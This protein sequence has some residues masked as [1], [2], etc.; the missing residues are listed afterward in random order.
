MSLSADLF[1]KF[2]QEVYGADPFPWQE[3]AARRACAG[4]WPSPIGLPTAAGKTAMIDIAVFALACEAAHSARRI[5][6]VVDRRVV[7]DEA[8]ERAEK[9]ASILQ[10]KLFTEPSSI[11]GRVAA[12]LQRLAG[13]GDAAPLLVATLRGGIARDDSWTESP[14]QPTVCCSTVDQVGSSILFRAYGVRSAYNWPMRAALAGN[15]ALIIIDEAHTSRP[16]VQTMDLVRRYRAWAQEPVPATLTVVQ[17]SA[18]SEEEVVFPATLDAELANPI[19]RARWQAEKPTRL[20][21][22]EPA[23]GEHAE[24]GGFTALARALVEQARTVQGTGAKVVGVVANRVGTARRVFE[25]LS[26]ELGAKVVLFTGRARPY[27]R[28]RLWEECRGVVGI[29]RAEVPEA[30][31][32][33]VATQCIE[34]GANIDFDALV[35]ELA[36]IDA[37]EQRFGRLNRAG[38]PGPSL[39]VIVAQKDQINSK[40][41]DYIYGSAMPATWA[42][43]VN[44]AAGGRRGKGKKQREPVVDM[45]V[46]AI[47]SRSLKG[48][49]R[50]TLAPLRRDAPVLMPMHMDRLVQT[51]PVSALNPDVSLFLHG[52]QTGPADV[53]VVWRADIVERRPEDWADIVALCPP[54][55]SEA[56]MVPIWSV[57]RW[58]NNEQPPELADVEGMEGIE[59]VADGGDLVVRWRGADESG[60][61]PV[62]AIQP[63]DTIVVPSN[64]GGCD[65]WG[66]TGLRSGMVR[67]IGD[68]VRVGSRAI[69]RLH[70]KLVD[71]WPADAGGSE[72]L[73]AIAFGLR[74]ANR[75]EDARQELNRLSVH[76]AATVWVREAAGALARARRLRML[77]NPVSEGEVGALS[78]RTDFYQESGASAHTR[79]VPLES[80]LRESG[81]RAMQYAQALK[82]GPRLQATVM[83]AARLHDI[84]K[85]DPRFQAWLHGGVPVAQEEYLAKS[86]TNWQ[87]RAAIR[88]AREIAGYPAGGRHEL[89]S[90]AL[91]IAGKFSPPDEVDGELLLHL[92]ASHHGRCRP[93]APVV[94]DMN[95]VEVHYKALSAL[96]RHGLEST[97]SGLAERFW[98]LTRRY[99]WHGLAYLEMLVRLTD[100][101][102]S[103][104]EQSREAGDVY[105]AAASN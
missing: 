85:A 24:T 82:L 79:E 83:W 104:A 48:P 31:L 46:L 54:V 56:V 75:V 102:Q 5:F 71:E 21:P 73:R 67:D 89:Q 64:Y 44:S 9:L 28:D 25:E 18:T 66:W 2:F 55:A 45:G 34:V 80:H 63:G 17:M 37:L 47:R 81:D 52:P 1:A 62:S 20:V 74:T 10:R 39:G 7:V 6:F 91:L 35:T 50:L 43:L 22:V 27:D 98:K 93:F 105:A 14:L 77:P 103:E 26:K 49:D 41:V 36:S 4:A 3:E 65:D 69:L 42:F 32:F 15:D 58:M 76:R 88:R 57:R 70:D 101:R 96:S 53:Q 38:R 94:F 99:G 13:G 11:S 59:G 51:S 16:F 40:H 23:S 30:P 90:V 33:V 97:G 95:P 12:A 8:T 19:L 100:H 29:G 92:I 84:G 61:V 68:E 87:N 72:E 60:P 78:G 86:E